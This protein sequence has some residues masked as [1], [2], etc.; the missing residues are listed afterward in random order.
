TVSKM[1]VG[2]SDNPVAD[3]FK[4]IGKA[5]I[6]QLFGG[7]PKGSA[8]APSD[9]DI[10]KMKDDD[11]EFSEKEYLELRQKVQAIY[12]VYRAKKKREE[13][14]KKREEE[15]KKANQLTRL[16]EMRQVSPKVNVKTAVSKGSAETGRNWGAE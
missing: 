6:S 7:S 16:Y 4:R 2:G 10:A 1:P 12:D 13:E 15:Q 11:D 14:D 9:S 3:E 5:A 8:S